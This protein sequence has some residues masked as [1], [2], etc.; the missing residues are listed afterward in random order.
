[1]NRLTTKEMTQ[2][3]MFTGILVVCSQIIIPMPY[4][5]PMTL[6]TLVI[7]LMGIL[8]GKW[9]GSVAVLLYLALG[10]IGLPVF[11]GFSGGIGAFIGPTG[12]FLLSFPIMAYLAGWGEEQSFSLGR[13]FGLVVGVLLNFVV[14]LVFFVGVTNQSYQVGLMAT[15][16]P[17]LPTTLLKL[18]LIH[19]LSVKLKR[20]S[21]F[22]TKRVVNK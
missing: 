4:G 13:W 22:K 11:S 9:R 14:G 19:F 17:F 20:V 7:P 2:I 1:M 21:I 12:G 16:I 15:V 8:L 18:I 3:A 6:Q 5:V 10:L